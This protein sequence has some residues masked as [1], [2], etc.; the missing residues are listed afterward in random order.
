[1]LL[2]SEPTTTKMK[3]LAPIV[4]TIF[5]FSQTI[6]ATKRPTYT[7]PVLWNDLADLDVFR[8]GS[9]Y[10]YSASTMAYSPGAPILKSGDLVN[11]EYVSRMS[12][13]LKE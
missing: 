2:N 13:V 12:D 9:E 1:M 11:W 5:A 3:L 10:Y 7:N 8:V 6:Y 4:W